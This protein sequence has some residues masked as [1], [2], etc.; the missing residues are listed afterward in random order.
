M[1]Q[2]ERKRCGNGGNVASFYL[3]SS[4]HCRESRCC[5]IV[6]DGVTSQK[7]QSAPRAVAEEEHFKMTLTLKNDI[8]WIEIKGR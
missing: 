7:M 5:I 8:D 2:I 4:L 3:L 6:E 1:L